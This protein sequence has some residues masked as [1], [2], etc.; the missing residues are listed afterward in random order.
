MSEAQ[1]ESLIGVSSGHYS[2]ITMSKSEYPSNDIN[3]GYAET[4]NTT[5][6]S[7][8]EQEAVY[9]TSNQTAVYESVYESTSY[10][11]QLFNQSYLSSPGAT[12]ISISF[13]DSVDGMTYMSSSFSLVSLGYGEENGVIVI[14]E[15]DNVVIVAVVD[16]PTQIPTASSVTSVLAGDITLNI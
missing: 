7:G 13:N 1:A 10:L 6:G 4:Y 14:G 16:N 3:A 8:H 15:K 2:S 9:V 12:N 5:S 11:R